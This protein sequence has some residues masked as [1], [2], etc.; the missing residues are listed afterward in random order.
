MCGG[1]GNT[2]AEAIAVSGE[3]ILAVGRNADMDA[4]SGPQTK[5]VD[6]G[7][8]MVVPGLN[9]THLHAMMCGLN[10]IRVSL[11]AAR[12]LA[13]VQAAFAVRVATTPPNEWVL[14]GSGWHESQLAEGRLP[15]RQ[16][17]DAVC[18]DHPLFLQRGGHVAVAN[19]A[20]LALAGIDRNTPDPKG[21]VIV[22]DPATGDPTGVLVERPAFTLVQKLIPEPSREERMQ[23]LKLFMSKLNSKGV[24][25][26]VEPGLSLDEIAAYMEM[27]RQGTMTTRAHVLQRVNCLEDVTAL[28][29]VLAPN[30]GDDWLRIGGFKC[31]VDGGVEAG[32]M[33]E[34]YQIVEGEQ[35]DPAFVGK[36][37]LP[38]GGKDELRQMF[39]TAAARGWQMQIHAVGDAAITEMADLIEEVDRIHSVRDSR[40]TIMHI[41]LPT[42]AALD[43]IKRL[44]LYTTVQ[45]HPVKLGHNML[46]YWGEDRAAR[47]IPVRSI[48]AR[49]IPTGGGT[50]APVV[51]WNPFE[52]I[53]WMTTRQIFTGDKVRVLGP[54]EAVD[55]ATALQLY[56][57][58]SAANTF[59]DHKIGTIEAG[60]LADL[61]VL[62]DD[63]FAVADEKLADL[64]SVLTL[65]G[66]RVVHRELS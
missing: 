8:R 7:G 20:A 51:G 49:G 25:A 10:E 32:F 48:V 1:A 18:P 42:D 15:V 65:V 37:I 43:K 13:D 23:G 61:A 59:M 26:F 40:W 24:T 30:F 64:S 4:V 14:G 6:L 19:S 34:P 29:S 27:W 21:G 35:N 28:S 12:T 46:R 38:P 45:D 9:D 50:D 22:R 58:G 60:K 36:L 63:L 54:K 57:A 47:S 41:F 17:L 55:R 16:E 31:M 3:R 2:Q 62:S 11:E 52:S 33:S 53:W 5:V 39:E 44:G 56:T 66:G